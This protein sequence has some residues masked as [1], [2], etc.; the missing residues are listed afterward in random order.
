M[1][2]PSLSSQLARQI[3]AVL[4][5]CD[6]LLSDQNL[7]AIFVDSRLT[8]WQ[9]RLTEAQSIATR[10][11]VIIGLQRRK[12]IHD[13]N[14]LVLCLQVLQEH[15]H[16][17]DAMYRDLADLAQQAEQELTPP[18]APP[19]KHKQ[20]TESPASPKPSPAAS[21][22]FSDRQREQAIFRDIIHQQNLLRALLLHSNGEGGVGKST[23]L[24]M[25]EMGCQSDRLPCPTLPLAFNAYRP[26][27][28][29]DILNKTVRKLGRENFT[30]YSRLRDTSKE[31]GQ[32]SAYQSR[33]SMASVGEQEE[34][35]IEST[36]QA[37][38]T[39]EAD[40]TTQ[41]A[42]FRQQLTDLFVTE[43]IE[44]DQQVV[45]LVD[46]A[47]R[48]NEETQQWLLGLID[49]IA[50]DEI[51]NLVM[52][53]AGRERWPY[54]PHWQRRIQELTVTHFSQDIVEE[55]IEDISPTTDNSMRKMLAHL[56]MVKTGGKPLEL[57]MTL[58]T[59][60]PVGGSHVP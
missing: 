58:E 44:L 12:S 33:S 50:N 24:N 4:Q 57:T 25:F 56:L 51:E 3:R 15:H 27:S 49:Q 55:I 39:D 6:L 14:A 18:P 45:W 7:K 31:R 47:E 32:S 52:V 1:S 16:H 20:R 35:Q 38:K 5:D 59:Y 9:N 23:I 29:L 60:L 21:F 34:P 43:L 37:E 26:L 30:H 54:Q 2:K 10:I 41:Q 42:E 11:E 17:E 22:R 40:S 48:M 13:K 53:V 36:R 19:P 28:C 46:T 8:P